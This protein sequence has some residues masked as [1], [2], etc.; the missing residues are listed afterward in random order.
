M[1][2]GSVG[3]VDE[4]QELDDALQLGTRNDN[5]VYWSVPPN[6]IIEARRS[7]ESSDVQLEH[8]QLDSSVGEYISDTHRDGSHWEFTDLGEF[9]RNVTNFRGVQI[10]TTREEEVYALSMVSSI[11]DETVS[12]LLGASE[13]VCESA[14]HS[15]QRKITCAFNLVEAVTENRG[16][17]LTL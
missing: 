9:F 14:L 7:A 13:E 8:T 1:M 15:A 6:E 16:E 12:D 10:L 2:R 4:R 3:D 11:D 17:C 5:R